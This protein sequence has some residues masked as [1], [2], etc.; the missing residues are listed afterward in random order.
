MFDEQP[1]GDI[2]GECKCDFRGK[3]LGDGCDVCNPADGLRYAK[4][5]IAEQDAELATLRAQLAAATARAE[6]YRA[7]LAELVAAKDIKA[8]SEAC[9]PGNLEIPVLMREY[10]TRKDAAWIEARA[11]LAE[12]GA[13]AGQSDALTDDMLRY[14]MAALGTNSPADADLYRAFWFHAIT[15]LES[16]RKLAEGEAG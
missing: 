8:R 1:D 5:T 7:A 13:M 4:E 3:I 12:S 14:A 9:W 11:A 2:H 10:S 15:A 6:R 16:Q